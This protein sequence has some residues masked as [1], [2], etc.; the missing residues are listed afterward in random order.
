MVKQDYEGS[1]VKLNVGGT[2]FQCYKQIFQ[3]FPDS[4]L[5]RLD[6]DITSEHFFDRDQSLFRCIL[7]SYRKGTIH[8]SK[9]ICG[10]TFLQELEFWELSPKHVA[11]CCWKTLYSSEEDV[12][13]MNQL[14]TKC[15]TE[16]DLSGQDVSLTQRIWIFLYQPSSSKVAFVSI[17][18]DHL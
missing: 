8:L 1:V 13:N 16:D 11:P 10:T 18:V 6:C 17:L 7:D 4:R 2:I 12:D 5:A 3:T 9:D 15:H 14:L